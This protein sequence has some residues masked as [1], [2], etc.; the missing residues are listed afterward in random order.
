ML[1]CDKIVFKENQI[2]RHEEDY[3]ILIKEAT[4]KGGTK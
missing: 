2:R 1:T 3:F 4:Q